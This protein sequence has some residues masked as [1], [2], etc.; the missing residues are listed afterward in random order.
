MKRYWLLAILSIVS[1]H[2]F[3]ATY[4]FCN[5]TQKPIKVAVAY[6]VPLDAAQLKAFPKTKNPSVPVPAPPGKA[7]VMGWYSMEPRGC[8]KPI[9]VP[10]QPYRL[11]YFAKRADGK[12][13]GAPN[14]YPGSLKCVNGSKDFAYISLDPTTCNGNAVSGVQM[15]NIQLN[16]VMSS[17][18]FHLDTP[19]EKLA[20]VDIGVIQEKCL[21][22]YDDSHQVHSVGV[23]ITWTRQ[24]GKTTMKKLSH[25]LKMRVMGPVNIE[26]V[27]KQYVDDCAN[28]ALNDKK[29]IYILQGIVAAVADVYGGGNGAATGANVAA[30]VNAVKDDLVS[31]LTNTGKIEAFLKQKVEQT[32]QSTVQEESHW[33]YWTL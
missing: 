22:S 20:T 33:V 19:Q 25:C 30:Y 18:E 5:D 17:Q 1:I 23:E 11:F 13:W 8:T 4:K 7:K 10:G 28:H 29:T 16:P 21:I 15:L 27:A 14:T 2:S 24:A 12:T 3:A 31:C 32:L 6:D 9:V 26:G